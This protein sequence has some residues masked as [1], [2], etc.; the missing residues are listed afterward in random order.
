MSGICGWFIPESSQEQQKQIESM[1]ET[2]RSPLASHIQTGLEGHFSY[3]VC[4]QDKVDNIAI[5]D[6][7]ILILE[8][9]VIRRSDKTA[10]G[11]TWLAEQWQNS[12][13]AV[14]KQISGQFAFCIFDKQTQ[15]L[16]CA[17][18]QMGF[19]PLFYIEL[20]NGGFAFASRAS[21][22]QS[23]ELTK[24]AINPQAIFEYLFSHMVPSPTVIYQ[25]QQRLLAAEYLEW[26]QK[27]IKKTTYWHLQYGNEKN[28]EALEAELH[29]VLRESIKTSLYGDHHAAFLSGG[30]DS[31]TVAGLYK[32]LKGTAKTYSMGFD[33]Q[34]FDETEF[35]RETARH[36]GTDHHEYYVTPQ[37]VIDAIPKIAA[38]YDQPFGNASAIPAYA[39]AKL[40][41]SEGVQL[42]LGGDGG[43]ELFG[44][45]ERYAKQSVFELYGC[46]PK[47]LRAG[48][49][50]PIS[51]LPF[52]EKVMPLRKMKS[53]IKQAKTPLPARFE[54]YNF[55]NQHPLEQI[56][57]ADFLQQVSPHQFLDHKQQHWDST[58]AKAT[59]HKM[60]YFDLKYTLTDND[61]PKVSRMCELAGV[62]IQYPLLDL[63]V[64]EFSARLSADIM[65]K[66]HK[67]RWFF[68]HAMRDFL[69]QST[70]TKSKQGF[71]LPFGLWTKEHAGLKEI[72]NDSL[73]DFSKRDWVN[74]QW[75]EQIKKQHATEHASYYGV[76]LWVIMMLEQWLASHE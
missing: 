70:L 41:A 18:D 16:L 4:S 23:C 13:T 73:A 65:I 45:N 28:I 10:V 51:K 17:T 74:V 31:S 6:R 46:I 3:A 76:M 50:E 9:R 25:Q 64:I 67:L 69:P 68:K 49:L 54:T 55:L 21:A 7:F 2:M 12:G 8:G 33:A 20:A 53:Y 48:L 19:C 63:D 47:P 39:C 58:S 61:L 36:F 60:L 34:G 42:M 75:I 43:D 24:Q 66:D 71:G 15:T 26:N 14:L 56:F 29:Q 11:A 57:N 32:E 1:A 62:E 27:E 72:L 5:K 37:D 38:F 30:V 59:L 44:G 40:A 22:L 35:A 52:A